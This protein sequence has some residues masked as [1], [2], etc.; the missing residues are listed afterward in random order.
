MSFFDFETFINE[1]AGF[2]FQD[3]L[4]LYGTSMN[5]TFYNEPTKFSNVT[6]AT[7]KLFY[8]L[9]PTVK[10]SGIEDF[11]VTKA[12]FVL[13]IETE[14]YNE[15][16]KWS[17]FENEIVQFTTSYPKVEFQKLPF[18]IQG[19]EIDMKKSDNPKNWE[20]SIE[21]GSRD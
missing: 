21:I 10:K 2:A 18:F 3:E 1:S 11:Q 15:E 4:N 13:D 5:L 7:G 14:V 17:D 6:G 19:V 8:D 20:V 16:K 12:T 9:K